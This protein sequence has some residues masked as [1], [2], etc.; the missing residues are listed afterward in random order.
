MTIDEAIKQTESVIFLTKESGLPIFKSNSE[1]WQLVLDCLRARQEEHKDAPL[2]LDELRE[3]DGQPI[4]VQDIFFPERSGFAVMKGD[5][6]EI[7]LIEFTYMTKKNYGI[8]WLAYREPKEDA[9]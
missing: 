1:Y 7:P 5:S 2:T 3:M 9:T 8:T 6:V 4:W